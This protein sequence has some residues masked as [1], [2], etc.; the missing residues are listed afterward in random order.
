M[1]ERQ[2]TKP[3]TVTTSSPDPRKDSGRGHWN[4]VDEGDPDKFSSPHPES[5]FQ[6]TK[7]LI[8]DKTTKYFVQKTR[9]LEFKETKNFEIDK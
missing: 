4:L 1:K 3:L 8:W 2:E 9:V 6:E 7:I 5:K